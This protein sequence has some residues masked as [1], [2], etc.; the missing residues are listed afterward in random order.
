MNRLLKTL[1]TT[2][3]AGLLAACAAAPGDRAIFNA[4][5][6]HWTEFNG[7]E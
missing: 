7:P 2:G 5:G 4:D 6:A 3:L 1:L